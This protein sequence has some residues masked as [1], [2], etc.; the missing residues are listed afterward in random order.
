M[1]GDVAEGEASSDRPATV[2]TNDCR[3]RRS[4]HAISRTSSG[5][6]DYEN[7]GRPKRGRALGWKGMARLAE[8]VLAMVKG[9]EGDPE[10]VKTGLAHDLMTSRLSLLAAWEEL[11]SLGSQERHRV[12]ETV[13]WARGLV[14]VV[15][16]ERLRLPHGDKRWRNLMPVAHGHR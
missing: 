9:A 1:C 11:A 12:S 7:E 10:T 14:N 3:M 2:R 5:A 6:R 15:L 13:E 16:H 4:P 8:S